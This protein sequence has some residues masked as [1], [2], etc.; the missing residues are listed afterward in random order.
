[1]QKIFFEFSGIFFR[2]I[3]VWGASILT[4]CVKTPQSDATEAKPDFVYFL[5]YVHMG[6]KY[7]IVIIAFFPVRSKLNTFKIIEK[8]SEVGIV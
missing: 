8:L 3:P 2:R 1:V 4:Q 7:H 6:K 5:H